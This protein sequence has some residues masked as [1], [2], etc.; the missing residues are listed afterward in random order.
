M[1]AGNHEMTLGQFG[2]VE[3]GR[4]WLS[5]TYKS[6]L[7]YELTTLRDHRVLYAMVSDGAVNYI[8]ICEGNERN[9]K[10]RMNGYRSPGSRSGKG[11]TNKKVREG[12]R[13]LLQESNQVG[14]WALDP[15]ITAEQGYQY[16]GLPVD[17]VKGLE[18]PLIELFDPQWNHQSPSARGERKKS[19]DSETQKLRKFRLAFKGDSEGLMA[20]GMNEQKAAEWIGIAR[21][22]R[23]SPDARG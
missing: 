11:S 3:A 23:T 18:N 13:K 19:K 10:N 7:D 14:I 1:S 21:Q 9:L 8:G 20:L 16:Q 4:W 17:L 12:I 2:F 22:A 5:D 15:I 6:G